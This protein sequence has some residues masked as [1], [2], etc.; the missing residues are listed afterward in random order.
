MNEETMTMVKWVLEHLDELDLKDVI[1]VMT[2]MSMM[3]ETFSDIYRKHNSK[4]IIW[5]DDKN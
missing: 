3:E 1:A 5:K 4:I 2:L